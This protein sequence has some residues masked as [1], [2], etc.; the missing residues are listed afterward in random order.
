MPTMSHL[1]L[2]STSALLAALALAGPIGTA[3]ADRC[4]APQ[5]LL[6]V[7]KSSS[8]LGTLPGGGTKWAAATMAIGEIAS[9]YAEN[10]DFGLQVFPFPDRCEPGRIT[11]DVGTNPAETII[12]GLGTPPPGAGNFTPMAQT[13][14]VIAG[15]ARL[16]DATRTNHVILVTDGW[17]WCS[18][19]DP[20][21]RF[22]P[23]DSITRLRALGLTVHV[24]GFGA[25]VDPLTLNRA[26]VAAG[27]E[28]PGCDV[29]LSDPAASNHCYA[30]AND[31]LELRAALADIARS[32]SEEVCDGYDNDCDGLVDEGYDVDG[33][34][35][36]LC[37][38]NPE[39]P[40]LLDGSLVDCD[41]SVAAVNPGA[42]EICNAIDDDCDGAIDPGCD[43]TVGETRG[44]GIDLGACVAGTQSCMG[45]AWGACLGS[46][47]ATDEGC[48]ALDDDCDGDV[49]DGAVCPGGFLCVDGGCVP[50]DMPVDDGDVPPVEDVPGPGAT[51]D[52]PGRDRGVQ[53]SDEPGCACSS[54]GTPR[55]A[56]GVWAVALAGLLALI[57]FARI[58][59]GRPRG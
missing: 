24:V 41:D 15:Y 10:I 54:V 9:T 51:D 34:G 57:A 53:H 1:R 5:V 13:L 42:T 23:V 36:S 32:I 46:T 4:V 45:G 16:R 48:N 17:Q 8:M 14:D 7:D 30:Q 40:G 52:P 49:D 37:G 55:G 12:A 6:V 18:P 38:W 35:Y 28:L 26:A 59:G 11:I 39:V 21:T 47:A 27:T 3:Q 25:S 33:D 43:C 58:A 50:P 44:C 2:A 22:T 19:Y 31:L 56:G 20:T 29:T